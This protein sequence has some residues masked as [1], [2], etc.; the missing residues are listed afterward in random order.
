MTDSEIL[1]QVF[2]EFPQLT[3][4]QSLRR[5][6]MVRIS[7]YKPHNLK[8]M[9]VPDMLEINSHLFDIA[10]LAQIRNEITKVIGCTYE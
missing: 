5:K 9:M 6:D 3:L 2:S 8:K 4:R 7:F 1:K 10:D